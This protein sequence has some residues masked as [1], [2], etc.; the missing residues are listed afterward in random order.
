MSASKYEHMSGKVMTIKTKSSRNTRMLEKGLSRRQ[1]IKTGLFGSIA[2]STAHITACTSHAIK[3]PLNGIEK[4]PYQFLTK[5]DAVMLSAILPVMV[6]TN[7]PNT[8]IERRSAEAQTLQRI[9][10][11]LSRLGHHN[12][13]EVRKLFDLLQ[14]TPARGLS[15]GI[16]SSWE[17][18]SNKE[19]NQFL[20]RWKFSAISLFN[21]GYN[22]LSDILCFAWYSAP[23]NTAN[24]GYLGPPEHALQGLPQFQQQTSNS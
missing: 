9:D 8:S 10:L 15:T 19:V 14:F 17:N 2:L 13:S 4:S 22:A 3:S 23:E 1:L 7:W 16:W 18:A 20:N 24:A 12:L 21:S 11:F 6:A 5:Q